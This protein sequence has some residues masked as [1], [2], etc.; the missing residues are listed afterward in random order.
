MKKV[1]SSGYLVALDLAE[2]LVKQGMPFRT[3]HKIV[4]QLVQGAHQSNK[5]LA[6]LTLG[7]I[8]KSVR[9]KG[10][11]PKKL[12][13][14]ISSTNTQT[15]LRGRTSQGSSGLSEQKRMIANRK[16]KAQAYRSGITKRTNEVSTAFRSLSTK[17]SSLVK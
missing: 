1:A 8:K 9:E 5:S 12:L 14:I 16:S 2:A 4:G 11:D 3:A 10:A 15:S 6:E 17:V 7:E 13:K